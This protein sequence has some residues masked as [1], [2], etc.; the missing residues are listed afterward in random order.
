MNV[1]VAPAGAGRVA[2]FCHAAGLSESK[3]VWEIR[4]EQLRREIKDIDLR[5]LISNV[6]TSAKTFVLR[7]VLVSY[8]GTVLY[9]GGP[10]TN[11]VNGAAVQVKG[12]NSITSSTVTATRIRFEN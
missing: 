7:G 6:N 1:A 3:D 5:G 11:L 12:Q 9:E 8:S 4:W 10:Q 2:T